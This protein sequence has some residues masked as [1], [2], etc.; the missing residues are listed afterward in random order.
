MG[1]YSV[2]DAFNL[3]VLNGATPEEAR[4]LAQ[5]VPG[6]SSGDPASDNGCA[7]GL[8][9]I[10]YAPA[11]GAHTSKAE[12]ADPNHQA[13]WALKLYRSDGLRPWESSRS[14]WPRSSAAADAAYQAHRADP[15]SADA[16]ANGPGKSLLGKG[17]DALTGG[18]ASKTYD[19]AAALEQIAGDLAAAAAWLANPK[20]WVRV[21]LVA[22]GVA[23]LA[24]AVEVMF[25]GFSHGPDA[26]Q[27]VGAAAANLA[28]RVAP[29]AKAP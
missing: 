13:Q 19:V 20:S 28:K 24:L 12:L 15:K 16:W 29:P 21:V 8:F 22:G 10:G 6:E 14:M 27:T 7:F 26:A 9:Q 1:N 25:N 11:C 18:A 3:L 4:N 17:A 5:V 23:V 2:A